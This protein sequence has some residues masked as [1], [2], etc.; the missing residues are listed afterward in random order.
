MF[1]TGA[2]ED[3]AR[4]LYQ[5]VQ[6]CFTDSTWDWRAAMDTAAL[7]A[8][9]LLGDAPWRVLTARLRPRR[10]DVAAL[11]GHAAVDEP[12]RRRLRRR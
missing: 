6:H 7:R 12:E 10:D 5:S 9:E 2:R 1:E 8:G 3:L 11:S 4:R